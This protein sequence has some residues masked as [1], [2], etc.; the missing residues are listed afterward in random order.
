VFDEFVGTGFLGI[1][2]S[3]GHWAGKGALQLG[4]NQWI[5]DSLAESRFAVQC[6]ARQISV[7]R[8]W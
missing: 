1:E 3:G 2:A 6:W 5:G 7:G 8:S 4:G